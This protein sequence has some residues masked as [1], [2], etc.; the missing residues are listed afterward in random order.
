MH[1]FWTSSDWRQQTSLLWLPCQ[2]RRGRGFMLSLYC[3]VLCTFVSNSTACSGAWQHQNPV[4]R[5][6]LVGPSPFPTSLLKTTNCWLYHV[7][8]AV[9]FAWIVNL[10]WMCSGFEWIPRP[11]D[12]SKVSF[13]G[14]LYRKVFVQS[15]FFWL[16]TVFVVSWMWF[17]QLLTFTLFVILGMVGSTNVLVFFKLTEN[18]FLTE[19]SLG[20]NKRAVFSPPLVHSVTSFCYLCFRFANDYESLWVLL[21]SYFVECF[22]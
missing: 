1:V 7:G 6:M 18:A 14:F 16:Y 2:K 3:H 9:F 5:F 8:T 21:E 15:N 20:L 12:L 4:K 19:L 13:W 11:T 10:I 22:L 17:S